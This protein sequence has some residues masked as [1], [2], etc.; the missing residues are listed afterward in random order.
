MLGSRSAK[1]L[2]PLGGTLV[3]HPHKISDFNMMKQS[4]YP[5]KY[6]GVLVILVERSD[7][8]FYTYVILVMIYDI[9]ST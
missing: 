6:Q 9:S 8:V 1:V 7:I 2:R 5:S 3:K 4:G